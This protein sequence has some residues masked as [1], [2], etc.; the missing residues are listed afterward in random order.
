MREEAFLLQRQALAHTEAMLLVDDRQAQPGELDLVF[1][2]G[3]GADHDRRVATGNPCEHRFLAAL[4]QAAGEPRDFEPEGSKPRRQLA[5]MLLGEDLG[6]SHQGRLI[7]RFDRMQHG[8]RGHHRL[9][10]ADVALQQALHRM[11]LIEVA[12]DF[13]PGTL[14]RPGQ[15]KGQ[16]GQQRRGQGRR[17]LQAW[18]A[19]R[20]SGGISAAQAELLRQQFVE[21]NPAP[22]RIVAGF[23]RCLRH[24]RR[25][26]VQALDGGSEIRQAQS[27][28]QGCRQGVRQIG[29]VERPR[30][31]ASQ[32]GLTE[33][34]GGWINR[35]QAFR[36]RLACADH[37]KARMNDF[38]TEI[39]LMQFAKNAQAR[40]NLH[41]LLLIRIEVEKPHGQRAAGITDAHNQLTTWPVG[42]FVVDD[43]DVELRRNTGLRVA[44]RRDSCFVFVA[45]RQV[46]DVVG[47]GA[48][49]EP[50]QPGREGVGARGLLVSQG[51]ARHRPRPGRRAAIP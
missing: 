13:L 19:A 49:T 46:Q 41:G 2:Q 36:Q 8:Q 29:A 27:F 40:A 47:I 38:R 10:A 23:E 35:S 1:D 18:C 9:A 24:L 44:N 22:G 20:T 42:N 7:T 30:N 28:E 11:R 43:L 5:V 25:R 37:M 21:L 12:G 50:G 16:C 17:R 32:S 26:V 34:G 48:Q 15:A 39:A 4:F 45:Q 14:L 51:P 33:P 3:V 6:G 31:Q